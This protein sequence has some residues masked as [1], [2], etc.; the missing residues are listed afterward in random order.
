MR[1][2]EVQVWPVKGRHWPRF[3]MLFVEVH[4][5]AGIVGL[6]ES[7][8]YQAT[9]LLESINHAGEYLSE[10]DP[11]QIELHWEAMYRRGLHPAALSGIE[12]ALWDIVGQAAGQPI[13][14]LLGGKCRDA[15]PV[16]VDGFFRGAQYIED[17]Y[18]EMAREAV[19]QG[20]RALK[21]DVDEPIPAAKR[22]N[23]S[24]A[25]ADLRQMVQMVASVREAVGED[26]DLAVDCHGAFDVAASVRLGEALAPFH[27]L[28]IEDP[29]PSGNVRA[30]AKVTQ[31]TVTPICTGELLNT[32]Y[33]FRE[34][35][36]QQ[37]ADIIMPDL[38]RTGGILEMKKI[39]AAADTYYIPVAPH[40]MV[41]PVATLAS[42]HLCACIPNNLVLEYQLG[43]VPWVQ[44]LLTAPVAVRDGA[45]DLPETAGL[46]AALNHQVAERYRAE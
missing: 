19:A 8:C 45:V 16:Y 32:R 15:I 10:K 30:L 42:A 37:A 2:T 11:F 26:I 33:E 17:E 7:L 12:T 40:N 25:P 31:E 43:D 24:L 39:A 3:P 6:G 36:E 34:L 21:M 44:D 9:G 41:G 38:A 46:G 13:Y 28:W 20:F 29:V 5:D 18:A 27:L 35:F 22:F 1:V 4:T 23:R 14:N